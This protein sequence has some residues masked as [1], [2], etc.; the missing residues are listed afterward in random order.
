MG[1]GNELTGKWGMEEREREEEDE[2]ERKEGRRRVE[3][4]IY[5]STVPRIEDSI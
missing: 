5:L 2:R 4:N 1:G 3:L